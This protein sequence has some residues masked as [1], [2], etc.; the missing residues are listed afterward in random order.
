ML[1]GT[2]IIPIAIVTTLTRV[3]V[4]VAR[5]RAPPYLRRGTVSVVSVIVVIS[6]SHAFT[7]CVLSAMICGI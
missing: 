5:I 2:T 6:A 3:V 1:V 4:A 7:V